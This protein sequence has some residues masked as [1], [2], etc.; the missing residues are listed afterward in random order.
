ML[1][2][3]CKCSFTIDAAARIFFGLSNSSF[4]SFRLEREIPT[5]TLQKNQMTQG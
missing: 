5:H 4:K 1:A 3:G 2:V